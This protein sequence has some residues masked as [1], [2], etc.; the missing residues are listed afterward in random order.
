MTEAD[1]QR[2]FDMA[3]LVTHASDEVFAARLP[4]FVDLDAFAR[5][6]AVLV[7]LGNPDS[8]LQQ[9]QNFYIYV[10]PRTHLMSFIPWD[11]DHSF[12]QFVPFTPAEKQQQLKILHPWSPPYEGAPFAKDMPNRFL[13]RTFALDAF[14]KRYLGELSRVTKTLAVPDRLS[15]QVDELAAAIGPVVAEEP[16]PVLKAAFTKA[17][18]DASFSRPVNEKVTVVPIK[19]FVRLRDASVTE[20]LKALDLR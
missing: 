15:K 12:G 1:K 14:R 10:H 20:Q 13:E 18:G 16:S 4:T 3:D 5:Y 9:G 7:W 17:L 11:Q 19:T 8:P 2:I 6:A